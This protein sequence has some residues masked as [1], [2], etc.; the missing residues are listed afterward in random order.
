MDKSMQDLLD[1]LARG[2]P[3]MSDVQYKVLAVWS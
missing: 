1:S 3:T 2:K